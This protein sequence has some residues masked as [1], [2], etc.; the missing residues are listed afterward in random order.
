MT[1]THTTRPARQRVVAAS[2]V[3]LLAGA[4]TA[5]GGGASGNGD[6]ASAGSAA[7]DTAGGVAAR[8]A[9]SA[10]S[11]DAGDGAGYA[12]AEG[13]SGGKD[14]APQTS[15]AARVLP[16]D[17]DVV[18]TGSISV[19]V[20]DI[21]RATDRVELL[22]LGANGIVFAEESSTNPRHPRYG[23]A[24]LTISNPSTLVSGAGWSLIV[25]PPS[26]IAMGASGVFRV[27]LLSATAGT[28]TGSVTIQNNSATN[29]FSFSL[30]GTVN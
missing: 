27:R 13:G 12:P 18:Y 15:T 28:Y 21:R 4:L 30:R 11:R 8:P 9:A 26:S 25:E 19:R 3:L 22:A 1:S 16:S 6:S 7:A 17:R 10:P 14:D 24:T 20:T 23:D 5:C 29:P 2:G